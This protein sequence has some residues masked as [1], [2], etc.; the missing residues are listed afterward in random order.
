MILFLWGLNAYDPFLTSSSGTQHLGSSHQR[1]AGG[2]VQS[3]LPELPHP[4]SLHAKYPLPHSW[5]LCTS[6]GPSMTSPSFPVRIGK[7]T[8]IRSPADFHQRPTGAPTP[9]PTHFLNYRKANWASFTEAVIDAVLN[10]KP[11]T[12]PSID[13][14]ADKFMEQTWWLITSLSL[15]ASATTTPLS[16]QKSLSFSRIEIPCSLNLLIEMHPWGSGFLRRQCPPYS[17]IIQNPNG[18]RLWSPHSTG[19]RLSNSGG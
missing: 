11:S 4:P 10:L 18:G 1:P 16:H 8:F 3:I 15:L 6:F 14:A 13:D 9:F 5:P 12:L 2:N 17:K 7:I 19:M